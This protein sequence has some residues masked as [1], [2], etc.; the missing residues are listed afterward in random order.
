MT[1]ASVI[2]RA[3]DDN[4]TIAVVGEIDLAN[5]DAVQAEILA[6]I[7]NQLA[8]VCVDLSALAYIDSAGLRLL[9][10]LGTRLNTLQIALQLLV[11]LDS[12]TRRV[13]E[14]SGIASGP[15]PRI[16]SLRPRQS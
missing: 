4:V 11:P 12:P 6:A 15:Y 13:I 5:A 16:A 2:A 1:T 3:Q 9:F 10:R 7:T 8:T 14:L